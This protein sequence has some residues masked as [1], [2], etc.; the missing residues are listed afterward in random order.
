[1]GGPIPAYLNERFP[2]EIRATATAFVYHQGAIFG[3]IAPPIITFFA[4]H[5]NI[6]FVYPM[7]IGSLIGALS[8][9]LGVAFSPET[10]GKILVADLVVA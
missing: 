10:K 3:G 5:Y 6:G 1:M 2:T 7:L 9:V 4:S 8:W